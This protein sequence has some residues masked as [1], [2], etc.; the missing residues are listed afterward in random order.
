MLGGVHLLG[1]AGLLAAA[2][3]FDLG[4][5]PGRHDDAAPAAAGEFEH[6]PDQAQGGGLAGEAADHLGAA[7]DLDEGAFEQVGAADALA[8]LGGQR[9]CATRASR[10]SVMTAIADG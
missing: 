2:E 5:A 4:D 8:V 9:R 7:A 1:G 6:G 10:L 3:A